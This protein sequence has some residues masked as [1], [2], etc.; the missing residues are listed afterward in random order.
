MNDPC[1]RDTDGE[2]ELIHTG[3]NKRIVY[4]TIGNSDDKL[5]QVD[6]SAYVAA[7]RYWCKRV[8]TQTFGE[9]YSLPDSPW[10]NACIG[11]ETEEVRIPALKQELELA[12]RDF[13]QD[14]IAW[15]EMDASNVQF[16]GMEAP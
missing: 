13:R 2:E 4:V 11:F 1:H 15:A 14:S 7:V 3:T 5:N 8:A 12:R 16:I 9:W 10:Q 6:W